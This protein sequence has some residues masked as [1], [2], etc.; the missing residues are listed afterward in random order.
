MAQRFGEK[1]TQLRQAK[2]LT[3]T[4]LAKQL[5]SLSRA[6]I[7]NLEK[8]RDVPSLFIAVQLAMYLD[9]TIDSLLRDDREVKARATTSNVPGH[10]LEGKLSFGPQLSDVRVQHN[11]TQWQLAQALQL[12]SR[13]Y[14]SD[15]ERGQR[16]PSIELVIKI[17]DF[18]QVTID[19]LLQPQQHAAN[20]E[21]VFPPDEPTGS[22]S[23]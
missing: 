23:A 14:V 7:A 10:G 16:L 2:G 17:A 3:Q 11:L 15:L 19:S 9:V 5:G 4:E 22:P 21:A 1:L 20:P 12:E 8:G 13:A 6:H 18:F